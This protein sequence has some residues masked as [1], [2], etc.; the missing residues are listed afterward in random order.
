MQQESVKPNISRNEAFEGRGVIGAS[1]YRNTI[2][3]FI[4]TFITVSF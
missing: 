3:L 2:S 4:R 1:M